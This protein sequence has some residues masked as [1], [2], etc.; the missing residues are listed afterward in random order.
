MADSNHIS[1]ILDRIISS[2]C[3]EADIENLR[4]ILNAGAL[5]G[6]SQSLV[7]LGKYNINISEGRDIQIGDHTY[8]GADAEAIKEALRLVLQE[9]Q[10]AQRPRNEKVLLFAVK[11][12][13]VAR[14]KQSLHNEVLINLCK[15]AQPG[16]VKSVWDSDIKIGDNKHDFTSNEQSVLEVFN[17]EEIAGKLLILGNP[18]AGKTTAML[19]LAKALVARA[20]ED[21]DYPIP[22]LFNLSTWKNDKQS[23]REWVIE[24]LKSKYGVRKDIGANWVSDAKLL[25]M[26][27]GLDELKSVRQEHC[28]RKIN[29]FLQSDYRPEYLVVC[30]RQEEYGNYGI[31]LQLHGAIC[32]RNLNERQVRDYL[33]QVSRRDL[34]EVLQQ[35]ETLLKL[36]Q[37]PFW[38]SVLVLSE[39]EL[40]VR[41]WLALGS[42]KQRLEWL[43][44]AYVRRMLER[45]LRSWAYEKLKMPSNKLMHHW[46]VFL[47]QKLQR[48]SETEFLIEEIQPSW[49]ITSRQKKIY[50][51]IFEFVSLLF[52]LPFIFL[53]GSLY[54]E[55]T[56]TPYYKPLLNLNL[57]IR[58][59]RRVGN[60]I[61]TV[62]KLKWSWKQAR[63]GLIVGLI[64]GLLFGL[65][66]SLFNNLQL[67]MGSRSINALIIGMIYGLSVG[68]KSGISSSSIETKIIPNQGIWKSAANACI[69]GLINGLIIGLIISVIVGLSYGLN[70]GLISGLIFGLPSGV[71]SGLIGGGQACIQ[72]F[73]LRLILYHNGY[74]PWNYA[75]FLDYCTDRLLLQRV[76][77]RYRFIHRLIQEHFA[78]M[79]LEK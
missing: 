27:D 60:D 1:R 54:S 16:Q 20:E 25:P 30:S 75:R 62:E 26:L 61:K 23:I 38:L 7:Q 12:E 57:R 42:T 10:K 32:L 74:I 73:T 77:G 19:N 68:L 35:D 79:P 51:R 72:H 11:E 41:D 67:T 64:L 22:V 58:L 31:K 43:L 34:W 56:Y 13:V 3:T 6:S 39:Q 69:N 50:K 4:Q 55:P 17:Q 63:A 65:S 33:L 9:R 76:G 28:V 78:A 59:S 29:E 5:R 66:L 70:F 71:I 53:D 37:T 47:A 24:E 14:L 48:A 15:E 52:G 49:L 40:Q 18:G 2:N 8:Y 44:D 46:L 45:E 36:M 21:A